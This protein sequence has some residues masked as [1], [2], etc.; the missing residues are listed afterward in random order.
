MVLRMNER[1]VKLAA[2]IDDL[3]TTSKLYGHKY[4]DFTF[5]RKGVTDDD[6]MLLQIKLFEL[7]KNLFEA[8]NIRIV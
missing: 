1:D 4:N 5:Q 7:K 2:M 6:L 8:L 3:I